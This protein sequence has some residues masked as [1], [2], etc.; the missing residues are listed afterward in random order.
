MDYVFVNG[1]FLK[2][3]KSY[4]T[5]G[6]SCFEFDLILLLTSELVI[7]TDRVNVPVTGHE[8]ITGQR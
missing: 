5:Y 7:Q 4:L 1:S 2:L 3:M 8:S 6:M